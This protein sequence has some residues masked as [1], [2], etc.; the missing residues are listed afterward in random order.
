MPTSKKFTLSQFGAD[1]LEFYTGKILVVDSEANVRQALER[2][3]T[4]IGYTVFLASDGNEAILN[5]KK[6][7]PNLVVLDTMLPRLDGYE[8]CRQIREKSQTPIIMVS[9]ASGISEKVRGFNLGADDYVTKPFSLK[10]L[11]L[12]IHSALRRSNLRIPN[13]IHKTHSI[14]QYGNLLLNI[15]IRQAFKN[16]VN[17]KLTVIEFNLLELLVENAGNALSRQVIMDNVWGYTPQRF[18]DTR[19]V[20][21]HIAR[22]R[23][24]IE[25]DPTH[26]DLIITVRGSGYKV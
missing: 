5:F 16:E 19:I 21:V 12:R 20:D 22:L 14:I 1:R 11:K 7:Q 9:A 13:N 3:L 24:K 23:S 4:S 6:E 8:V 18:V 15:N 17:L 25:K 10:E 2:S 26:P